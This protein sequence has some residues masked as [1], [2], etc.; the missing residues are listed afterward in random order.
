MA[1]EQA[2]RARRERAEVEER[3]ALAEQEARERAAQA[4]RDRSAAQ[5]LRA[6]AEEL[7]PGVA[8]D[9]THRAAPVQP[10]DGS[11]PPSRGA[12]GHDDPA[13]RESPPDGGATR[14]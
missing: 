8:A 1:E 10:H 6:K 2:A 3:A 13:Y 11:V 4:E 12:V 9:D 5:E 7:A 14:R